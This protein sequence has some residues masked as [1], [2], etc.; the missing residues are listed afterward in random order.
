MIAGVIGKF[1][2]PHALHHLDGFF[3]YLPSLLDRV[4]ETLAD[5]LILVPVV[6]GAKPDTD[7]TLGNYVNRCNGLC[8]QGSKAPHCR[9][10]HRTDTDCCR[11]C[12]NGRQETPGIKNLDIS[13]DGGVA[14]DVVL[15]PDGF[16]AKLFCFP[17]NGL[18]IREGKT[19]TVTHKQTERSFVVHLVRGRILNPSPLAT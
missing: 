11:T 8:Q 4:G 1:L 19:R 5:H 13:G 15:G 16:K 3:Q 17:G 7:A 14:G 10:S 6:S 18:I 2:A 12:R 9:G